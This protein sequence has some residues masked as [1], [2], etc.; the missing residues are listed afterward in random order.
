MDNDQPWYHQHHHSNSYHQHHNVQR[1]HQHA[2]PSASQSNASTIVSPPASNSV[3]AAQGLLSV[4]PPASASPVNHVARHLSHMTF[5]AAPPTFMQP[6]YYSPQHTLLYT[7][8]SMPSPYT[9]Y[10][11]ELSFI[12]APQFPG[13][14]GNYWVNTRNDAVRLLGDYDHSHSYQSATSQWAHQS[15]ASGYRPTPFAQS[16]FQHTAPSSVYPTPP[17]PSMPVSSSSS[18]AFALGPP[19][20]PPASR[21]VQQVLKHPPHSGPVQQSQR[22]I[23]HPPVY[24]AEESP[25]FFTNFLD[26]KTRQIKETV[27]NSNKST[28][29]QGVTLNSPDQLAF[30]ST[31]N[32]ITPLKRKATTEIHSSPVKR[33]HLLKSDRPDVSNV[34]TPK[35]SCERHMSADDSSYKRLVEPK[36]PSSA[37]RTNRDSLNTPEQ[38]TPSTPGSSRRKFMS[39]VA[40]PAS[41]VWLTPTSSRKT[42]LTPAKYKKM[43]P[44]F[45]GSPDL[46][47]YGSGDEDSSRDK[48]G[49][50]STAKFSARRTGDRDERAPLE[51]LVSLIED[52]LEAE[53]SLAPDISDAT[54]LPSDFFSHLSRDLAHPLLAP[55][56]IRKVTNYIGH[57]A[58]PTKREMRRN[59]VAANQSN[60]GSLNTPWVKGRMT[61][62]ETQ[63]LSR[64]LKILERSVRA[65]EDLDPF[66]SRISGGGTTSGPVSPKKQVKKAN[67]K[68]G[69]VQVTS[70]P[71]QSD[72]EN[73][74]VDSTPGNIA[75]PS[76]R[77][78]DDERL[79]KTLDI[80]RDSVLA[81]DCCIALL[82]SDRL[83]KQLY[84]EELITACLS[85]LKNQLTKIIYP[86]VEATSSAPSSSTPAFQLLVKSNSTLS[87]AHRQT[88]YEIF[89]ALSAVLPRI[90]MLI[91]AACVAMSDTIII[92]A[93]YIAIGPFFI[94]ESG[95]GGNTNMDG[96]A[97]KERGKKREKGEKENI[98]IRT[99]GKSA[100]RGLRLDA[101]SLIRTIFA[102]H[103]EQRSWIIEEIL[104]SL[105]KLSDSKHKAGQ[106][107]LR[108]GRS[109]RTVSALLLQLVQTSAHDVRIEARRI[110]KA[111]QNALA[112][113][114]QESFSECQSQSRRQKVELLDEYD[115]EEIRLYAS[116]LD[117]AT[118]AAKT[119]VLFLTQRSGKSKTVKN[120]NE[121][122]YRTIFD[123]LISDLLVVLFLPE[124]PAAS[125]L[126]SIACKYMVSSLDDIKSSN[127][128][129]SSNAAKTI[130]LDHLGVIAARIRSSLLKVQQSRPASQEK[131]GQDKNKLK[132]LD[133][134]LSKLDIKA[135]DRLL[136]CHRELS[137]HLCKRSSEDQAYD[138][139]RELTAATFGQELASALKQVDNWSS[140]IE[141]DDDFNL[142]DQDKLVLMGQK[143]KS[144]LREVWK[145]SSTDVFD[146]GFQ[147]EIERVDRLATELGSN[148]FLRS[149]FQP[150]LNIILLALD[151]PH[152]FMRTKALRAL[153]QI[154]TADA[155][156]LSAPNVR[157][158]I[159]GHL[160]D[161]SPA[162]RDA[163][164]ELIGRY[165]IDTPE[166]AGDYYVKIADRIA[167]TG[168]S[169]RKRVIKLLKSYYAVAEGNE[170]RIDITTRLVL[171]LL[172]EDES[173]RE[174]ATKAIEELWFSSAIASTTQTTVKLRTQVSSGYEFN[175][176]QLQNK[177]SVIM[178][179]AANF[180]D[181]QSPL[182]SL[183]HN[184]IAER[185]GTDAE[186]L[187]T[188]YGEICNTLIDGLVDAS[189]L[190]GFTVINC[191]RTIYL[192]TSA[193][194][195]I[196]SGTSASTLLP[197]LKVASTSEELATAE[198]LLKSFR[199]SVPHLPKTAIKFGNELQLTLQPMI[200]KPSGGGTHVL[201]EAVACMCIV[202]QHLTHDFV[203]LVNLLKSCN[204]RLQQAL[205]RPS[206]YTLEANDARALLLVIFIASSLVEHCDFDQLRNEHESLSPEIDS[207]SRGSI[208]EHVYNSLIQLYDKYPDSSLRVRVLQ[209]LGFLFRAQ[210]TLMTQDRSSSIM[211]S[212]FGSSDEDGHVRVLKIIQDFLIHEAEKHALK[213][214][215]T[216]KNKLKP[217]EVNM[218]ELVG[219][220]DGFADSG[221]SSAVVQRYLHPI[222]NAALAKHVQIQAAAI[223]ILTFTIKQ[224]L[225]HPLQSLPVIIALETSSNPT[226]SN[227]A[228][229][230]H[231]ILHGKHASLLNSR[232]IISARASFDYQKKLSSGVVRGFHLQSNPTALLQR[233][234][235]LVR[236]KRPSRQD[237]LKS[238]VK[239]F[240]DNT[241]YQS[242]QD[243]VDFMRYM[244][245]NF[246]TLEYKTQEEVLTVIKH[247]TAV[248]STTGVQVLELISPSHL[249][250]QLQSST[251]S[252]PSSIVSE[253][254]SLVYDD[255]HEWKDN[256][257][258]HL[259]AMPMLPLMRTSVIIGMVMLLKAY[260]KNLYSLSE[261]KCVKFVVGKKSAVGDRPTTRRHES[262]INWDRLPYAISPILT[263]LDVNAQKA[264]F[265]DIWNEDGVSAEPD[266]NL[267]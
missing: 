160:I 67:G 233:W 84:A 2:S 120:T 240:Q 226:I 93:V 10:S 200:L 22:T 183:I 126:L 266:D 118:K 199:I 133:E 209:C 8:N 147:E 94:V 177:V 35:K 181:K 152:I 28:R 32:S 56:L 115:Q 213:L 75:D 146:T 211:D 170:S 267:E 140:E 194:P 204:G 5:S 243:D 148:S 43:T 104:T 225:A 221:V 216:A 59:A 50:A 155:T 187:H 135:L 25:V 175:K 162:V 262:P 145:D 161:S 52:I 65:G 24:K 252:A 250:S 223:D 116:G 224:G 179:T 125:L 219:N 158:A 137:S 98:V 4:Y 139:A 201:Q 130:A 81:A 57:V 92:Q 122:E 11:Q 14:H 247:L 256:P 185:E 253:V 230:L 169:V 63:T 206:S 79:S 188:R 76:M 46:G 55:N 26:H 205:R 265:L 99:L 171:R 258:E 66:I 88:L 190:P 186:E 207:I 107:R 124:W 222:L 101:L 229:A 249:L 235:S 37:L 203:R 15:I 178:G 127:Q 184:I 3:H 176:S 228:S 16:V 212:I 21:P 58:R 220:T 236:E 117:S 237:F 159:E 261:E 31:N 242:T 87:Q 60:S 114:R 29:L 189:D 91:N 191:I 9:D 68:L 12:S 263:T 34:V 54:E 232:F 7:H 214:K 129:E 217:I 45:H 193:H 110:G 80:A 112:L 40:I 13:N 1:R 245:E 173:V 72:E 174:L 78:A 70:Q 18:L 164:V 38:K 257:P 95:D 83:A 182:G 138:S 180:K 264:R 105:I 157:R 154:I 23:E 231:A 259:D 241:S 100:M 195:S 69:G 48:S 218:E 108:D 36:T 86:F 42:T 246:A 156:I 74:V 82:A 33:F 134:I 128:T 6:N 149:S 89:Q 71:P 111:R 61:D 77:D 136:L 17:P 143:L 142:K 165:M 27:E 227:R 41:P 172:D 51:K 85:T 19:E 260:L 196:L 64:L 47:G 53:D 144:A 49:F 113:R 244:A 96:G 248:L 166:V 234:Y 163:A 121:A 103:E 198:Y 197:Y 251:K 39:H 238:L 168:L 151:A 106:F 44:N 255:S 208:I 90:N 109:I 254:V 132:P 150:I 97:E 153:G 167:D 102:H 20:P 123:N 30:K 73:V 131:E 62:V 202:V 210:P 192:F 215:E 119:I 141:N 239:V